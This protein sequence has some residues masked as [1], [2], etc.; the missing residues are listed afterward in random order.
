MD[1]EKVAVDTISLTIA[2][3]DYLVP[4][5]NS[6]DKEPSWDGDI[7][8]YRKAGSSHSK[9][10]LDIKIPIQVKGKISDHIRKK[11]IN[12]PVQISDMQN[13][14]RTGGTVYFVVYMD[15]SGEK[16][17]IYYAPMLPFELK[18][19]LNEYGTQVTRQITMKMLPQNKDEMTNVFLCFARD[20]KKQKAAISCESITMENL[21]KDGLLKE[22]S[23][24]FATVPRKYITP[25]EHLFD[26]DAYIY[27]KLPY[28]IELPVDHLKKID[29][30]GIRLTAPITVNGKLFY[31]DYGVI[32]KKEITEL[33]FGKSTTLTLEH[34]KNRYKLCFSLSGTLSE[35]IRDAEFI[36]EALTAQKF[37]V[38][39]TIYPMKDILPEDIERFNL[40]QRKKHL[41]WL[42]TVKKMLDALCVKGDL[43]CS[44]LTKADEQN[45]LVLKSAILDKNTVPLKDT[46]E[47]F[48]VYTIANL[49]ILVCTLKRDDEK[50]LFDV[51]GF[52]D[53]PISLMATGEN[54]EE[55]PSSFYVILNKELMLK[56]CNIDYDAMLTH[57]QGI[58]FS[59]KYS[60]QL[61]QLLLQLLCAYDE[62]DRPRN[63]I[64]DTALKLSEWLKG[65][66]PFSEKDILLLNYYQTVKRLRELEKSE[67]QEILSI[68]ENHPARED[69]FVGAYI[70]LEN[71][72]A[73][74]IHF[75][76]MSSEEQE[77]FRT[78]PIFH[79]WKQQNKSS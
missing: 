47:L 53:A 75:D 10:D 17:R 39:N 4:H 33:H 14:L 55:Y 43:D 9:K 76:M 52:N 46:K 23:F 49:K 24:G 69:I 71:Y 29:A 45:I 22:I 35:R 59:D 31:S 26:H 77:T 28:G 56:C 37:K 54:G 20:M 12:Y 27:A 1:I 18:K 5:I 64:L 63:D 57:I 61:I 32:Y 48:G 38:G 7:E 8:V 41:E 62:S 65:S 79:L 21:A 40:P 15:P 19:I 78:F 34:T 72:A 11:R 36:I 42:K 25:F 58:P 70:L 44:N 30:A 68:I 6:G 51:Y 73:A 66:D 50:K 74:Q 60:G 67:I 16:T 2:K 13:Y 3:S